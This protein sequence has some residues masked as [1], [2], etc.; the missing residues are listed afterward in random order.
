MKT[1]GLHHLVQAPGS[2]EAPFTNLR[3][4]EEKIIGAGQK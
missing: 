4:L 2:H 3:G 1:A